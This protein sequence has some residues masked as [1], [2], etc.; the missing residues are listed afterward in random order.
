MMIHLLCNTDSSLPQSD[1]NGSLNVFVKHNYSV[2]QGCSYI[3]QEDQYCSQNISLNQ[4]QCSFDQMLCFDNT[5]E[6][7]VLSQDEI[8]KQELGKWV[9]NFNIP[10]NATNAL[11]NTLICKAKLTYLPKDYRTLLKSNSI[12]V[13]DIREIEPNGIY[14]HFGLAVGI[15]IYSKEIP[16][17]DHIEIAVGIDGL[18]ISKSS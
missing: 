17:G 10:Q 13:A 8:V 1:T 9:V 5:F 6:E 4:N 3:N 18:P 11:L 12:K 15:N 7:I 16:F 2:S 14:Y